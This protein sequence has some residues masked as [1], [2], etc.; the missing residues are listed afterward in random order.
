MSLQQK[1]NE[2]KNKDKK[3]LTGLKLFILLDLEV[4]LSFLFFL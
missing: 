2:E 1:F 4:L 3:G